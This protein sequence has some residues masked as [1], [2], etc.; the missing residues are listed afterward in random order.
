[1]DEE[2]VV[3]ESKIKKFLK[4]FFILLILGIVL[5]GIYMYFLEP[6]LLTVK[7]YAV[8]DS[9]LPSSFNGFKIVQFSDIHF[10]TT[11]NAPELEKVVDKINYLRPDVIVFTGD[12]FN[13]SLRLQE[14]SYKEIS[15]ILQKLNCRLKKYAVL[16]DNDYQNKDKFLE[17]MQNAGFIVLENQNDLLYYKG[18]LPIEFI[19]SSS[20]LDG[21]VD[22]EAANKLEN[23]DL[24]YYQI[25]LHHEPIIFDSLIESDYRPNLL[26]TG[27]TLG[28]LIKIPFYG[29]LLKQDGIANYTDNYYHKKKI[30]MYISNGLGTYRYPVRFLNFPSVSLYR[31]YSE[32]N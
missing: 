25:W 16:G 32:E 24:E 18:N 12:L 31:L 20:S 6:H 22:M 19:G 11:I 4:V 13:S 14:N 30:S 21:H 15:D 29:N 23:N 26:L 7:E 9:E 28:G 17:I 27:H 2:I 10:G 5:L 1:M 8:N 3:E